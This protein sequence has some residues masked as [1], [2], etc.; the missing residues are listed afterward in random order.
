MDRAMNETATDLDETGEDIPAVS[1]E[2]LEAAASTA[3]A[4]AGALSHP[5]TYVSGMCC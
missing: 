2:A 5:F 3:R 4:P 1:D